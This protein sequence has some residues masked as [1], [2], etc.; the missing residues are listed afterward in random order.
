M[1]TQGHP[2]AGRMIDLQLRGDALWIAVDRWLI[3][4][5]DP[6]RR[7]LIGPADG[8]ASGGPLLVGIMHGEDVG[9]GLLVLLDKVAFIGIGS[10]TARIDSHH[11]NR[12]LAVNDPLGKLP[13][14]AAG[15]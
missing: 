15:V 6:D 3:V 14:R 12:R 9:V 13:A 1:L 10:E 7:E 8:V 11:V 2:V 4:M 5:R